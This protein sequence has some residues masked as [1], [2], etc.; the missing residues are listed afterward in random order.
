MAKE[1]LQPEA[2]SAFRHYYFSVHASVSVS[3]CVNACVRAF[4]CVCLH[5]FVFALECTDARACPYFS[6]MIIEIKKK[7][8]NS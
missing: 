2:T 5:V 4:V 7:L 8:S 3:G 1:R 6:V